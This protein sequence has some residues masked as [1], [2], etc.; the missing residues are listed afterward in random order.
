MYALTLL[1]V[2]LSIVE[3]TAWVSYEIPYK[4]MDVVTYPCSNHSSAMLKTE[5]LAPMFYIYLYIFYLSTVREW[6]EYISKANFCKHISMALCNTAVS[7]LLTHWAPQSRTKPSIWAQ[8][9]LSYEFWWQ[10]HRG[11]LIYL[12]CDAAVNALY[13]VNWVMMLS[14]KSIYVFH[15][16]TMI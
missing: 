16:R 15:L 6:M 11:C 4:Y 5:T 13:Q 2:L 12:L 8:A 7:P 14:I 10:L 9:A 1:A 3:F